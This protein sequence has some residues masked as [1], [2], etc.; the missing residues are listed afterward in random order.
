MPLTLS[1]KGTSILRGHPNGG[2]PSNGNFP[3][4]KIDNEGFYTSKVKSILRTHKNTIEPKQGVRFQD[5]ESDTHKVRPSTKGRVASK[6]A[7]LV[8]MVSKQHHRSVLGAVALHVRRTVNGCR[9]IGSNR[10]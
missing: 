5:R 9:P 3:T 6:N 4:V 10:C 2:L 7:G 8:L 1:A